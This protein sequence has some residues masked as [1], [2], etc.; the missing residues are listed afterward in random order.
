[1][2]LAT[3]FA[4]ALDPARLAVRAGIEPDPWQADALR[5]LHLFARPDLRAGRSS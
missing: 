2:R 1:M 5:V 3:G 4:L